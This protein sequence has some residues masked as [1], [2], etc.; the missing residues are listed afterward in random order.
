MDF[1][2]KYNR[3]LENATDDPNLIKELEGISQDEN[4]IKERFVRD[5]EF[6]TAGLRG[7]IGAGTFRMNIYT[8]RKAT[9]GLAQYLLADFDH[10]SVAIA[11]DSRIKSDVF[12][13]EAASVLAGNGIKAY[14]YPQLMP[15]PM[16]SFAVRQLKTSAGIVVTA[17]HNPSKYNGYKVYGPDGCQMTDVAAGK[18]LDNIEAVDTFTGVKLAGFEAGLANGMIEYIGQDICDL[19]NQKVLASAINPGI[20]QD[21]DLKVVYT[22]LNGTGNKPVR[23]VLTD[24]GISD[25]YVV[26][27]QENPDGNFP[28]APY[29]NPEIP[30]AFECAFALADKVNPDLLLATDPDADRV[31][32][33]VRQ[34]GKY[35]LMTGNEVGCMLIDYI[36]KGRI[37]NGTLPANPVAIKSIVST[38]LTDVI[39]E[40]YGVK[41]YSVLTGFKYIGEKIG[42]LEAEGK[43]SDFVFAFEESYGYM[44]GSFV[45]DKDA[46]T[47]SMLICEMAAY[48]K[49]QGKN[50]AD[51]MDAL[52]EKHGYYITMVENF[53]FE[54]LAGMSKM[55]E[56]MDGLRANPFDSVAGRAVVSS[57]DFLTSEKTVAATG[58]KEKILLPK[59]NVLFYTL[60][61][62][63]TAV[64]RPSGTE[65]KVKL[66]ITAKGASA[67]QAAE[68]ASEIIADIKQKV[69]V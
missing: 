52:Y 6:G 31:G 60:E 57:S 65:P 36:L 14:I 23:R 38:P 40:S 58:Q 20:A 46:V 8:V 18:V 1:K 55:K 25:V 45:R 3:W 56:L 19:F 21:A 62:N 34:N 17:S 9:Q 29:P 10:P 68:F 11:Y 53:A 63:C 4:E 48:Y 64:I 5:L 35:R 44:G 59:S 42:Q 33:A 28:T 24:M 47:A 2:A 16:L 30:Q 54:G 7:V 15:T 43:E 32:I 51:V 39:A 37:A 13:R 49:K 66:Y 12:A 41:I 27:E 50:L 67:D 69:G 26:P 22:P 61:N